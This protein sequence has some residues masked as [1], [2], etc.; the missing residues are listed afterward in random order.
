MSCVL[1]FRA[2]FHRK[3][4]TSAYSLFWTG[5]RLT[6]RHF[7]INRKYSWVHSLALSGSRYR[8]YFF[9]IILYI[10]NDN[11][12]K[13]VILFNIHLPIHPGCDILNL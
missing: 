5:N 2:V 13:R 6:D 12:D 8:V 3:N 9:I 10:V 11:S 1:L 4:E 7:W